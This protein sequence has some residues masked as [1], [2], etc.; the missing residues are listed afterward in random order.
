MRGL[1]NPE[2]ICSIVSISHIQMESVGA[3]K[4][5]CKFR[6]KRI[7]VKFLTQKEE[8]ALVLAKWSVAAVLLLS[9]LDSV[10]Y[11]LKMT[12][13]LFQMSLTIQNRLD[14]ICY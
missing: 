7:H 9:Y 4:W 14:S 13:M 8:L 6:K 1:V 2:V 10:G 3:E 11:I 12:K 5:K